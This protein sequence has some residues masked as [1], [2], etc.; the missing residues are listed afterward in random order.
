MCAGSFQSHFLFRSS[1]Y[2]NPVGFDV[3]VT[4]ALPGTFQGVVLIPR[5]QRLS[6]EQNLD[7]RGKLLLALALLD[8]PFDVPLEL[9]GL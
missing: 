7:N 3:A 1:V 5:R 4:P 6:G 9:R 2:E 8:E